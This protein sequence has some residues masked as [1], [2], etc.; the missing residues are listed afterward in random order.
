MKFLDLRSQFR[1]FAVFS[2]ADIRRMEADFDV[3]R[4][5][6]WQKKRYIKKIIKNYY[7]FADLEITE[8]VLFT[9]ANIIYQPSY[10]SFEMALSYY[11]LIPESVYGITCATTR[12]TTT[13]RAAAGDFI[14][15]SVKPG[16]F[17]GYTPHPYQ[18]QPYLVAE[19]EKALLDYF[20]LNPDLKTD[21]DFS[22]LRINRSELLNQLN[23]NKL[24]KYLA[25]FGSRAL[26]KRVLRFLEFIRHD[27]I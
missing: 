10:I 9:I 19:M 7:V 15:R 21:D 8:P 6:E 3:R 4:L 22:E 27:D 20:Y 24:N 26:K 23:Q 5:V 11:H 16:L 1:D 17:F 25:A 12:K 14:Y 13:F 18:K 2:V